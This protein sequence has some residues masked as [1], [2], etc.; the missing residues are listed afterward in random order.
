MDNITAIQKNYNTLMRQK[1][2][3]PA[4]IITK[5]KINLIPSGIHSTYKFSTELIL[6][7]QLIIIKLLKTPIP[8]GNPHIPITPPP[9]PGVRGVKVRLQITGVSCRPTY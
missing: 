9:P 3:S 4:K 5:C 2:S 1:Y 6:S 8:P 7:Y